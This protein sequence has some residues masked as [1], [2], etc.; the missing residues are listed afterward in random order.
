MLQTAH[1]TDIHISKFQLHSLSSK[2]KFVAS[3]NFIP[4][5]TSIPQQSVKLSFKYQMR[6]SL[7]VFL[8]ECTVLD[9]TTFTFYNVQR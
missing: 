4:I 5:S 8:V 2:K 7:K 9:N 1:C 6:K 3:E